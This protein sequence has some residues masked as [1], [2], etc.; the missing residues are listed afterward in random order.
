MEIR[1]LSVLICIVLLLLLAPVGKGERIYVVSHGW[2]TGLV[3]PLEPVDEDVC[4]GLR[5]FEGWPFA[6]IGWGDEGFY[7]GGDSISLTVA[8]K[9]VATPT[10]TVLH[11]V[12]VSSPVEVFFSQSEVVAID[13]EPE[14][15]TALCQFVGATFESDADRMPMDLGSGI[16]GASRFFRARG[17]YYF[18][19]TCNVW[20]LRALKSA[21]LPVVPVVG[22]RAENVIAQ[23]AAHGESIR[24]FPGRSRLSVLVAAVAQLSRFARVV[25]F[26]FLKIRESQGVR[27]LA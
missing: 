25:I 27:Q 22:I 13:L 16:Y 26:F 5:M 15:F 14:S 23:A 2:H 3:I 24:R 20:T 21:G 7:R 1:I 19:E 12:G 17:S 8:L 10:P 18:P 6:E 9:A 4:P 11:V